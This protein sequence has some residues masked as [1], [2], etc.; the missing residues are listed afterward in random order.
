[1]FC[2]KCGKQIEDNIKFCPYCGNK[3]INSNMGN[4]ADSVRKATDTAIN[5]AKSAGNAIKESTNGKIDNETVKDTVKKATNTA[6]NL[7]QSA[8]NIANEATDGQAEKYME[9]A[10]ETA[11]SFVDDAKQVTKDKDTSSFL[12][13]NNY[14][15]LKILSVLVVAICLLIGAFSGEKGNSSARKAAEEF[16]INRVAN[17]DVHS[18]VTNIDVEFVESDK[19][20]GNHFEIYSIKF[21]T[22]SGIDGCYLVEMISYKDSYQVNYISSIYSYNYKYSNNDIKSIKAQRYNY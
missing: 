8:K 9:K 14:K 18:P 22:K 4:I 1:M 21:Q 12:K 20:N 11:Q 16:V 13:K 2:S 15:N 3:I 10:K 19:L 7:A 17:R 6:K 5:T